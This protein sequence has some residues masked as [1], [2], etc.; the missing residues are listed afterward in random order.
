VHFLDIDI[1]GDPLLSAS[2]NV[3]KHPSDLDTAFQLLLLLLLLLL[4]FFQVCTSAVSGSGAM[5]G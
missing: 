4:F 5:P 2:S 1:G 3:P